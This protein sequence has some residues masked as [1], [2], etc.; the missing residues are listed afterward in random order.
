MTTSSLSPL[1]TVF[2]PPASCVADINWYTYTASQ[3]NGLV[4]IG[5]PTQCVDHLCYAAFPLNSN[6]LPEGWAL[7]RAFS[8][9]VCPEGYTIA[10]S[11]LS[12][13]GTATET[14][15]TCCP[16]YEIPF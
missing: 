14:V 16:K 4:T 13:A 1:T 6:C 3:T 15:A 2:T 5:N 7:S 8:P 12:T 9:G 11:S 10:C